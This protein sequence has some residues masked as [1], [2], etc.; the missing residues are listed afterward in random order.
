[1]LYLRSSRSCEWA[2]FFLKVAALD[3]LDVLAIAKPQPP[4]DAHQAVSCKD[5]V[6]YWEGL[7]ADQPSQDADLMHCQRIP[8]PQDSLGQEGPMCRP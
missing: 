4:I 1:M 5:S 7:L 2:S 6:L 8:L 3:H